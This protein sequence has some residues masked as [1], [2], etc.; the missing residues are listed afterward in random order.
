MKY[1]AAIALC[2]L[3]FGVYVLIG[4]QLG[5]KSG[6]GIIPMV[7]LMSVWGAIWSGVTKTAPAAEEA[8]RDSGDLSADAQSDS[9]LREYKP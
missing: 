4:G 5:W 9:D 2:A 6:G 1:L 3:A 7:I 8:A